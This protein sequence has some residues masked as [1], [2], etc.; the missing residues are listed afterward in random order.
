MSVQLGLTTMQLRQKLMPFLDEGFIYQEHRS[1]FTSSES[2]GDLLDAL[3][4]FK[5]PTG[6]ERWLD[7]ED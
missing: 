7:R 1:L 4:D 3:M 2:P 5:S 6:L